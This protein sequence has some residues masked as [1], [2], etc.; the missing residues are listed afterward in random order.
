VHHAAQLAGPWISEGDVGSNP[1]PFDAHSPHNFVTKAQGS[2]IF[3]VAGQTVYLGNQWNSGLEQTPPGPRNHDLLFWGVLDF[4]APSAV[5]CRDEPQEHIGGR[6]VTFACAGGE[7]GSVIDS[8][9]FAAFGTPG[10]S[11]GPGG[12]ARNATCD[13]ANATAVVEQACVGRSRCTI[14]PSTGVF[15]DPCVG[16]RKRLLASVRCSAPAGPEVVQQMVWHDT[17]DITLPAVNA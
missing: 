12:Q 13:A 16:T 10:G 5:V 17:I 3:Q 14:Q 6:P 15:G 9:E 2:A 4:A 11:C 8:V 1:A 7:P